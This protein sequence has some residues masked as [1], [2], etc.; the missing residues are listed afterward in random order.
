MLIMT[1]A[2]M[3]IILDV[4][5]VFDLLYL[6]DMNLALDK[7]LDWRNMYWLRRTKQLS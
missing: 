1:A 7:A 6:K 5:V 2:S 4:E 3:V